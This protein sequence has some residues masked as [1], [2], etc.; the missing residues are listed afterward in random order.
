VYIADEFVDGE[1]FLS[2]TETDLKE[3]KIKTGPRKR[4][5]N[6]INAAKATVFLN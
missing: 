3:L 5:L 4:L 2:L 6:L 1:A